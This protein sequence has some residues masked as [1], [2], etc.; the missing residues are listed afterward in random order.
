M[1]CKCIWWE[2][3]LPQDLDADVILSTAGGPQNPTIA[4]SLAINEQ[5]VNNLLLNVVWFF[6][7][8]ISLKWPESWWPCADYDLLYVSWVQVRV[9]E[10]YDLKFPR[11][12]GLLLKQLLYFDRYMK[13]LAPS[14]NVLGDDCIRLGNRTSFGDYPFN[15]QRPGYKRSEMYIPNFRR[16][17]GSLNSH[18]YIHYLCS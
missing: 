15:S 18:L 2:L 3:A 16:S 1:S 11:E 12:F 13:L 4:A 5:Q 17:W 9:S 14:L 10:D 7:F 8:P 6:S